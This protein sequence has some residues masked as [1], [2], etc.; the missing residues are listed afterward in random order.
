MYS[1][2]QEAH[3]QQLQRV[4][5]EGHPVLESFEETVSLYDLRQPEQPRDLDDL[6][7]HSR[8]CDMPNH[9]AHMCVAFIHVRHSQSCSIYKRTVLIWVRGIYKHALQCIC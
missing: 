7:D 5:V 4:A 3:F 2:A 1:C 9:K 8:G 6:A